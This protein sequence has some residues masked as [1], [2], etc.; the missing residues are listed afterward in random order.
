MKN[1]FWFVFFILFG[2][3]SL[4][5]GKSPVWKVCSS[6]HC[7]YVAGSVHLLQEGTDLPIAFV[8]ALNNSDHLVLESFNDPNITP[9]LLPFGEKLSDQLSSEVLLKIDELITRI[10][11]TSKRIIPNEELI[12]SERSSPEH[13]NIMNGLQATNPYVAMNM[14]SSFKYSMAGYMS[15]DGVEAIVTK[16]AKNRKMEILYLEQPYYTYIVMGQ[17]K[18]YGDNYVL[19]LINSGFGL[20]VMPIVVDEWMR[21]EGAAILQD[22]L[23]LRNDSPA[24]Y[25]ATVVDRNANWL[26]QIVNFLKTSKRVFV[27]VGFSHL[28]NPENGLLESL[29][30]LGYSVEQMP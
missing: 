14:I 30:K 13:I 18:G 20:N 17:M 24:V 15:N 9:K 2:L 25:K 4:A 10:H 19:G 12:K 8:A 7:I 1:F 21:G 28:I 11:F 23:E 29:R 5:Y 26:P 3:T 22:N 27:V 6:N 16:Y